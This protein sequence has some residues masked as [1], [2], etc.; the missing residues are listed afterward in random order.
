MLDDILLVQPGPDVPA[1][2]A[3]FAGAWTGDWRGERTGAHMG[4]GL[5][6][7]EKITPVSVTLIGG[8]IGRFVDRDGN[9]GVKYSGRT[10]HPTE[11]D[12]D[13]LMLTIARNNN[14]VMYRIKEGRMTA[15]LVMP[16]GAVW[17]G[18]FERMACC[19]QK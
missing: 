15:R 16:S 4:D 12:G 2:L 8:F 18:R 17:I 19:E 1:G 9:Y 14:R 6:A 7:F 13:A 5:Q 11:F 10:E 3:A